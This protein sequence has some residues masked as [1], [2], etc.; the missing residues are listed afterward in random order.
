M[1]SFEAHPFQVGVAQAENDEKK[2]SYDDVREEHL[3]GR[4][5]GVGEEGR[6]EEGEGQTASTRIWGR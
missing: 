2:S 1:C 5:V 4:R 6:K 3:A